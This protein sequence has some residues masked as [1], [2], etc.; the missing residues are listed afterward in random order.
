MIYKERTFNPHI[1][2]AREFINIF[3]SHNENEINETEFT[4][5]NTLK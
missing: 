5:H 1:F 3:K 2:M 4:A